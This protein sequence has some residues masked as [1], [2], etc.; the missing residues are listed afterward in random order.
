MKNLEEIKLEE[1]KEFFQKFKGKNREELLY[2]GVKESQVD[3]ILTKSVE[4]N[5]EIFKRE[6][7]IEK[8]KEMKNSSGVTEEKYNEMTET[9][10]QAIKELKEEGFSS[11]FMDSLEEGLKHQSFEKF[12]EFEKSLDVFNEMFSDAFKPTEPEEP[13]KKEKSFNEILEDVLGRF[14][15]REDADA[16][17]ESSTEMPDMS[18][19]LES[20]LNGGTTQSTEVG[21]L[22]LVDI[23]IR[24]VDYEN[25]L[26]IEFA[27][28]G[29]KKSDFGVS[30]DKGTNVL[31]LT[32]K[33]VSEDVSGYVIEDSLKRGYIDATIDI[34]REYGVVDM[35]VK[36]K[37]GILTITLIKG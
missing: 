21:R 20:V 11:A 29:R 2:L 14:G 23:D 10:A 37:R 24:T 15:D 27:I 33:G 31:H 36:Y 12:K 3:N 6:S 13:A 25:S 30:Y 35:K 9:V 22:D 17:K 34:D 7:K 4:E 28:P 5:Y 8:E 18:E 1:F 26:V 32:V 16:Q 19:I